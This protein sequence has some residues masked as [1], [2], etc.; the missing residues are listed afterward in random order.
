MLNAP[1]SLW[2][3]CIIV[4]DEAHVFCPEKGES[5]A[6]NSVKGLM[7]RGRKRGFCGILATQRL[8]K[9]HKD[10]AAECNN[11]LI[12][13]TGLDVDMKRSADELG[14]R[15][16]DQEESLRVLEPGEFFAYG[17]AISNSIIKVM[18]NEVLT[19]HPTAG[20]LVN[21]SIS[22]PPPEKIKVLLAKLADIPQVAE[23]NLHDKQALQAEVTRLTIALNKASRP[24]S[25]STEK[26]KEIQEEY[27]LKGKKSTDRFTRELLQSI[28]KLKEGF[29]AISKTALSY[30]SIAQPVSRPPTSR[31]NHHDVS[32]V[33][34]QTV[35]SKV[36]TPLVTSG[37]LIP[38]DIPSEI[39]TGPMKMLKAAAQFYPKTIT[40]SQMGLLAGYTPSAGTF[41]NYLGELRKL[42]LIK[43]SDD[44]IMITDEGLDAAGY[45]EPLPND[46]QQLLELWSNK[47]T[48][49]PAKMLKI[50]ADAYPSWITRQEL[51]DRSGYT[52]SAGTFGNYLGELR[53]NSLIEVKG[54][55]VRARDELFP[56]QVYVS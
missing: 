47:L 30:S 51:A 56:N 35:D 40:R 11:K 46:P 18:I 32:G 53:R 9:L 5:Q 23:K 26:I 41:G 25:I 8:S 52:A 36:E 1:K 43:V 17:P 15:T 7:T 37:L 22:R 55:Q 45:T 16:K 31:P 12:G 44:E 50:V 13:R 10:A 20:A 2:H 19:S 3:P 29:E 34:M 48:M 42:G 27:F 28:D 14:F 39:A 4:V 49:G 24:E 21:T 54:N 33:E 38:S 6:S